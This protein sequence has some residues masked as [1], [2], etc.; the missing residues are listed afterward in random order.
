MYPM[1]PND[2]IHPMQIPLGERPASRSPGFSIPTPTI[3]EYTD[4]TDVFYQQSCYTSCTPPASIQSQPSP[5]GW[6]SPPISPPSVPSSGSLSPDQHMQGAQLHRGRSLNYQSSSYNMHMDG[7]P[8]HEPSSD[9]PGGT[10]RLGIRNLPFTAPPTPNAGFGQSFGIPIPQTVRQD[11]SPYLSNPPPLP[12][13]GHSPRHVDPLNP[14]PFHSGYTPGNNSFNHAQINSF[15]STSVSPPHPPQS[16]NDH[17]RRDSYSSSRSPSISESPEDSNIYPAIH[18]P[19]HP[20]N[21]SISPSTSDFQPTQ[22][23]SMSA[24]PQP[25]PRSPRQSTLPLHPTY[26]RSPSPNRQSSY[27]LPR[28]QPY[29]SEGYP[30]STYPPSPLPRTPG[31]GHSFPSPPHNPSSFRS[32]FQLSLPER[33]SDHTGS[34]G[35]SLPYGTPFYGDETSF[36]TM[37][38]ATISYEILPDINYELYELIVEFAPEVVAAPSRMPPSRPQTFSMP[39]PGGGQQFEYQ[40]SMCTGKKKA[41]CIGI[42]YIGSDGPLKGCSKDA[43]RMKEFIIEKYQYTDANVIL[44]TDDPVVNN[45]GLPTKDNIIQAMNWLVEGAT[46]DDSLFFHFSGH[47][48]RKEDENGDEGDGW[49]EA[50]VCADKQLIVDDYTTGGTVKDPS[51][52]AASGASLLSAAKASTKGDIKG[53]VKNVNRMIKNARGAK[54]NA[55]RFARKTKSHP[56]D[57]ISWAGCKDSQMSADTQI[58]GQATGAMS[59]AFIASLKENPDQTYRQLLLSVRRILKEHFS[60]KPQLSSSHPM[61][62]NVLFIA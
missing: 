59:Y 34:D 14:L 15:P 25:S 22:Y 26:P 58:G 37:P 62:V 41:L 10:S 7:S 51:V 1:W 16:Y 13:R 54:K 3:P 49:D 32:S 33:S 47:G 12:G 43:L 35:G 8:P 61:D 52:I 45:H 30:P 56:A 53:F 19:D 60:Q 39:M 27:P 4:G 6:S 46:A 55:D 31:L 29:A 38:S 5:Y 9:Y 11:H 17:G 18:F 21:S 50:I 57:V 20:D 42:N 36:I 28:S 48:D 44:L 2:A 24:R 40:Y 23:R